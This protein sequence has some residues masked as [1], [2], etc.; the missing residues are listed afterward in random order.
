[1][2]GTAILVTGSQGF[3]G[4]AL[5]RRLKD[6]GHSVVGLDIAD[7]ADVTRRETFREVG[8]AQAVVHL[9]ARTYV[10]DSFADPA[11]FYRTN[12]LGTLNVL[13]WGRRHQARVVLAGTYVYGEPHYRPID[14]RHPLAPHSPYTA[15]KLLAEELCR[16]YHRDHG[17]KV[18]VLR[19]F[20][21]YGPGQRSE[22]LVPRILEGL[23]HGTVVLG[24]PDSRRDFLHLD[25]AVEAYVRA[26]S[27]AA[28]DFEVF[29]IGSGRSLSVRELAG[30]AVKAWGKPVEVLFGESRRRD[31]ISDTRADIRK[32]ETLLG[33]SPRI[34]IES[35]L[36]GLVSGLGQSFS[37]GTPDPSSDGRSSPR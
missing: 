27:Y 12:V 37:A 20:N 4:R 32:A 34:P 9:A 28:S 3:V 16:G 19:V 36:A 14:E 23:K 30:L 17:L 25:D 21:I 5:V 15:S 6:A 18:V 10:P 7:G 1:M 29:N 22:F 8:P 26:A 24:D 2:S 11:G 35:G 31:E 13:E 33:W